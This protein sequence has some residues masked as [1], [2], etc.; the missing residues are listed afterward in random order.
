LTEFAVISNT[1]VF[2][3]LKSYNVSA[4]PEFMLVR[5]V[6]ASIFVA[7]LIKASLSK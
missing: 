2:S 7:K 5:K 1:H 3:V 4:D 6:V